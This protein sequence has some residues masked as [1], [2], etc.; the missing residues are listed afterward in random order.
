MVQ[1]KN[2]LCDLIFGPARTRVNRRKCAQNVILSCDSLEGRVTPA[3][4]GIAH[5]AIAAH[6]HAHHSHTTSTATT[7]S[8]AAALSASLAASTSTDTS[9]SATDSTS[10]TTDTSSTALSAALQTLH[11]DV[12]AI[13]LA[14][15]TTVGQLRRFR[16]SKTAS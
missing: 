7:T 4:L 6:V 8:T 13:Q 5:H 12:Q 2:T 14:S 10:G 11:N 15:N 9:G 16:R 1:R 3:H